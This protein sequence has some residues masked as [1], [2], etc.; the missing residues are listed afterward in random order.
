M[1]AG[2]CESVYLCAGTPHLSFLFFLPSACCCCCC[3]CCCRVMSYRPSTSQAL[4]FVADTVQQQLHSKFVWTATYYACVDKSV[5][6]CAVC[7]MIRVRVGR[8]A[9]LG[10]CNFRVLKPHI[11]IGFFFVCLLCFTAASAVSCLLLHSPY[12][13]FASSLLCDSHDTTA[14]TR[15]ASLCRPR[16]CVC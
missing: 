13:K 3:C 15:T 1:S 9:G 10:L 5:R 11:Y 8:C 14:V 6:V 7:A 12:L 4:Y 16:L 2:A